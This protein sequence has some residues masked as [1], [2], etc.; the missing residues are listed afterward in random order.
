[1]VS[2]LDTTGSESIFKVSS[3][4]KEGPRAAEDIGLDRPL[5]S[6]FQTERAA[7]KAPPASP[8]AA[9]TYILE[10]GVKVDIFPLATE[11]AA[12]PPERHKLLEEDCVCR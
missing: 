1:M 5:F 9:C 4:P 2:W 3:T 8:A 7:P 6:E 10:K 12:Q 11:L